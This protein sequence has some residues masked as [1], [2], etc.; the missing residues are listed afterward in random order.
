MPV[1]IAPPV[2]ARERTQR[3]IVRALAWLRAAQFALWLW[4]PVLDGPGRYP[5][6]VFVCYVL[7]ALW[8]ALFFGVGI[9]QH[10]LTPPWLTADVVLAVGYAVLVSRSYP[11]VEAASITNWVIPPLCGVAVTAA[12]YA[13]RLRAVAVG[14]VV[15]AWLVGAWPATRTPSVQELFSNAA[16]MALFAG[17]AGVT[18]TLLLRAAREADEAADR[19][20]D[21]ERKEAAATAR[22]AERDHQFTQLHDTVLHTLEGIARGRFDNDPE[23]ARSR[24][25][26]DAEF[27]R[28][29]ITSGTDGVPAEL[30]AALSRMVRDHPD[31]VT[32]KRVNTVFDRLPPDLPPG[33]VEA[34]T[35]AAREALNNVAEHARTDEAWLTASAEEGAGVRV[36]VVDR[37]V[38]FDPGAAPMGLGVNHSILNRVADAGGRATVTGAPGE[39]TIVE[40][41]WTP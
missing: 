30:G 27:L 19:A 8:S 35:G 31:R 9:R 21:A 14:V 22:D 41:T 4:L 25:S 1:K 5:P 3:M 13:G 39:G 29:L 18:G 11:A 12:I 10:A 37:G 16:M 7:A 15:G 32:L 40:M 36:T 28:G 6:Q 23:G 17:V 20:V 33:V 38:G 34:L 2:S 24:C 26:L